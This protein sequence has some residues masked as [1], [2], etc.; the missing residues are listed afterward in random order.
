MLKNSDEIILGIDLGT[1]FSVCGVYI[2]GHPEIIPNEYGLSMTPS[3]VLFEDE[4]KSV[5][6]SRAKGY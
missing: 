3:V 5:A 6:G 2:N 1:D 4:M